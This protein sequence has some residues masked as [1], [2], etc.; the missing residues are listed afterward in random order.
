[1]KRL[2]NTS[3][4]LKPCYSNA[5]RHAIFLFS[6]FSIHLFS[7]ICFSQVNL[8]LG[9]PTYSSSNE[10]LDV[11]AHHAVD[12]QL[13][14]RWS[15]A[16]ADPQWIYVDLGT[17]SP[18]ERVVIRWE[19]ASAREYSIQISDSPQ[20]ESSWREVM[21]KTGMSDEER[22]D[23]VTGLTCTGRYLRIYGLARNTPFG[24]SMRELE[25][26]SSG[27]LMANSMH[28]QAAQSWTASDGRTI[29]AKFVKLDSDSI[30]LE[31]DGQHYQIPF[32]KLSAQSIEM[33]KQ[34]SAMTAPLQDPR[35]KPFP[36]IGSDSKPSL[37]LATGWDRGMAKGDVS[38]ENLLHVLK[39][40]HLYGEQDFSFQEV[41]LY[42]EISYLD[43]EQK[44]R[45]YIVNHLGGLSIG[46]PVWINSAGFPH[47]ALSYYNFSGDFEGFTH[48]QLV[49]DKAKQVV[50]VQLTNNTPKT[51]L[52]S[53]HSPQ[54]LV[55]NFIQNRRKANRNYAI[56]YQS[57]LSDTGLLAIKSE[58]I[59]QNQKSREWVH[60][61]MG[62]KFA[63]L[64]IYV[65]ELGR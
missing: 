30:S 50:A 10:G 27:N 15:S 9:K 21:K 7:G 37:S 14:T 65:I 6:F 5:V 24:F 29:Q 31:M 33:A 53:N 48:L 8:A 2:P 22:T 36:V 51:L 25:V 54:Y 64:C 57:S 41:K 49:L 61:F 38:T 17:N 16:F 43:P 45:D 28:A 3:Q 56:R 11:E 23:D 52:L 32:S 55:Y 59:D 42:K 26:Y 44:A 47:G 40:S 19:R 62:E 34:F 1:M 60:L 20:F 18:I 39:I 58:L 13:G 46:S 4:Y 12:G 35:M 63:K